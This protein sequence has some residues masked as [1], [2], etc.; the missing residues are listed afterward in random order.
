MRKWNV[1][2][3]AALLV[4]PGA[5]TLGHE[6][7]KHTKKPEDS[8]PDEAQETEETR[9]NVYDRVE[10]RERAADLTGLTFAAS[11]GAVGQ[12]DLQ[13]RPITR[14]G[15]LVETVP[16]MPISTS[17]ADSISI[18]APT[19]A[20]RSPACRSTCRRTVTVRATPI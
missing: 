13:R 11:E 9:L 19:S 3:V 2:V 15:E 6:P 8:S 12:I 7:E 1:V 4:V 5:P 16:G 20:S 10:I 18:T 14:A 17:C